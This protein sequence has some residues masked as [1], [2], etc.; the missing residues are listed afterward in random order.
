MSHHQPTG[1]RGRGINHLSRLVVLPALLA[2][3][4][5]AAPTAAAAATTSGSAVNGLPG[6]TASHGRSTSVGLTRR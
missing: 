5:L 3:L 6:P 2:L 4:A 1:A